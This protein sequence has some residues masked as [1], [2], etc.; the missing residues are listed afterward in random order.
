MTEAEH[1]EAI[2]RS[3]LLLDE[4]EQLLDH[5]DHMTYPQFRLHFASLAREINRLTHNLLHAS[6]KKEDFQQQQ[7]L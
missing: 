6:F 4:L 1:K 5:K 7:Q 2:N 3:K